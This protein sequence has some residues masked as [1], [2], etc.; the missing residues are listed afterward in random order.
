MSSTHDASPP[1]DDTDVLVQV[2]HALTYAR[3]VLPSQGPLGVFVHH[4]TLHAFQ[5][6]P[7]H[8]AIA[9]ACALNDGEGY[10][11]EPR[12]REELARGRIDEIDLAHALARRDRVRPNTAL[13]AF[14]VKDVERLML[15]HPTES[16]PSAIR[17][18]IDEG[19]ALEDPGARA[20]FEAC[21]RVV[22]ATPERTRAP[23]AT[24][25]DALLELGTSDPA[26]VPN[27]FLQRFLLAYL[28]EGM[29]RWA[30]PHRERGLLVCAREVLR[31][32]RWL[33]HPVH[34][35]AAATIE[36]LEAR[37]L[38]PREMIAE[39]CRELGYLDDPPIARDEDG[40]TARPL[41]Q[42]IARHLLL[43][44]GFAGM[45]ARLESTPDD[46]ADDAPPA[47]LEQLT[48]LRLVLDL[49]S[50]R[51]LARS[52][53]ERD[54]P[55]ADSPS[56]ARELDARVQ[57]LRASRASERIT[58]RT[59]Q[60]FEVARRLEL[61]AHD[62]AA[63]DRPNTT[64]DS[65][66]A[67]LLAIESF[68][69]P[70]R[71][72]TFHEAYEHHHLREIVSAVAENRELPAAPASALPRFQV[73]FCID[74]R[75]EGIRRHF[76]SLGRDHVTFG[77]AGF[78]GVAMQF[79]S[80]DNPFARALCPVVVTPAHVVSEAS[81]P[82]HAHLE[83]RRR[84]RRALWAR[85]RYE[86][87]Y[88]SRSLARGAIFTAVLGFFAIVPLVLRVT[89]PRATDRFT[90][91][92]ASWLLPTPR[93]Q[94]ALAQD[95]G[96]ET[97]GAPSAPR[98]LLPSES[99]TSE[100]PR[101]FTLRERVLRVKGTLENLGLTTGFAPIVALFGHGASSV[102]NPHQSAY[103]CGACGGRNGGPNAR[104]FAVLANDAEVRARLAEEGITIPDT[105]WFVGGLHDTTT[106]AITI[107]DEDDVPPA[108]RPELAALRRSLDRAR[109]LSAHERCRRFEHAP[110]GESVEAALRHVEER[111]VDLSQARPEYNHA[112]NAACIVGRR[113]LT[114]GLFLDRR[115]FLVS[116]DPS[117]DADGSIL[118]RILGAV[119]PVGAGI[120][121]EYLFS[122]VDPE[123]WGA[124]SKLPHNLGALLGVLE[125]ASGD[126]RTG[127]P[128]QM[129]EIHEPVR[130]LC[131][132]EASVETLLA[133][134]AAN[135]EVRE[136]VTGEW[137]RTVSID[138]DTG[139]FSVYGPDGFTPY[140]PERRSLAEV[141]RWEAWYGGKR[142][143]VGPARIVETRSRGERLAEASP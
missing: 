141:P 40:H 104:A 106:D 19:G 138:P 59:F 105:T 127:L 68:D 82:A 32:G 51:Q 6:M 64:D 39:L 70:T 112:T 128:K 1:H 114:R 21:E 15:R 93:T 45:I 61:S 115:S 108:L 136:L 116:Y 66:N 84:L 16:V 58:T 9:V 78:F 36:R 107:F 129:T 135:A 46:R 100:L 123:V 31:T 48:V 89:F 38:A 88:A 22:R 24:V 120:N 55:R 124:G 118:A 71:Q 131:I 2:D 74:D 28:D 57:S 17:F 50:A 77:V 134:A 139:V 113:E 7:F 54:A 75:E 49:A 65:A 4:N 97:S 27:A 20:L 130:L 92:L 35:E 5:S 132:I 14:E 79:T 26:L 23:I 85:A 109:Q 44:P 133:I 72:R 143:H 94:L 12:F 101:G 11:S 98:I 25:R 142:D 122:T 8:D 33:E 99:A 103:D 140:T 96:P 83:S 10:L 67:L 121:L 43:L 52:L 47:S 119:V 110:E 30:M 42:R 91:R 13:A 69:A 126:L 117:I 137:V 73:A 60:L 29:A 76:E 41:D 102:N 34:A 62:I 87:L 18:A 81:D 111:A 80:L 53:D 3:H 86:T 125:G 95:E 63:F 90:K 56:L 37:G